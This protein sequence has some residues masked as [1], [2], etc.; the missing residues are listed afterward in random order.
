MNKNSFILPD[1]WHLYVTEENQKLATK[2]RNL[3]QFEKGLFVPIGCVVAIA[4]KH[5]IYSKEHNDVPYCD[6]YDFGIE[7]TTKQF[8]KYVMKKE[9]TEEKVD[10][11]YLILLFKRY[12]ISYGI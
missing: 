12:N 1:C 6:G 3:S 4:E 10:F 7:I 8:K 5:G 11:N 9:I 2:W